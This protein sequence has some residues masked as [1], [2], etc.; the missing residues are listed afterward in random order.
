MDEWESIEGLTAKAQSLYRQSWSLM[1]W[2][3]DN[4]NAG[5]GVMADVWDELERVERAI[6]NLTDRDKFKEELHGDSQRNIQI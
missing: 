2:V 1:K 5:E 4:P 6:G 3:A